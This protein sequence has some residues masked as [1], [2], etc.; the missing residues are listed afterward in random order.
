MLVVERRFMS[1]TH[2]SHSPPDSGDSGAIG[3][4]NR[5][6]ASYNDIAVSLINS[7]ALSHITFLGEKPRL[8]FTSLMTSS[9]GSVCD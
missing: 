9:L 1:P 7:P 4:K 8:F 3:S 5:S 6:Y 2:F